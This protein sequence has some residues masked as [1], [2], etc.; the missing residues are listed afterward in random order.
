MPDLF[1]HPIPFL[2]RIRCL[3][4]SASVWSVPVKLSRGS[5]QYPFPY[6]CPLPLF[7]VSV[8]TAR[9]LYTYC[10]LLYVTL[11]TAATFNQGRSRPPRT[12]DRIKPARL[13]GKDRESRLSLGNSTSSKSPKW[14]DRC[15]PAPHPPL[16]S[17]AHLLKAKPAE[18]CRLFD[19]EPTTSFFSS[20]CTP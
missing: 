11:S 8:T 4:P 17:P 18:F 2:D 15:R 12:V 13:T 1:P 19:R 5:I 7:L 14:W 3:S 10:Q 20:L 9:L 16:R 6:P